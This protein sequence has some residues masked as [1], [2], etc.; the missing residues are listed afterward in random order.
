MTL[1]GL[2]GKVERSL[3]DLV[4]LENSVAGQAQKLVTSAISTA[5]TAS[6]LSPSVIRS[7]AQSGAA[8]A[9]SGAK[10]T[11]SLGNRSRRKTPSISYS[12]SEPLKPYGQKYQIAK[13]ER[14]QKEKFQSA[15]NNSGNKRVHELLH[16][17]AK[18]KI[19]SANGG[20]T[21]SPYGHP[22]E[23]PSEHSSV[24]DDSEKADVP[25]VSADSKPHQQWNANPDPG[26][27]QPG[28]DIRKPPTDSGRDHR[29][30]QS[31][32]NDPYSGQR[33]FRPESQIPS[34]GPPSNANPNGFHDLR[35]N[36]VRPD[37][38]PEAQRSDP[39]DPHSR[40]NRVPWDTS[41]SS[42]SEVP[43]SSH[44]YKSSQQNQPDFL[45][46]DGDSPFWKRALK[47][48]SL[49]PLPNLRK[50]RMPRFRRSSNAYAY[51]NLAAWESTDE[52]KGGRNT[53]IF[54]FFKR[55]SPAPSSFST[56]SNIP[57]RISKH[58]ANDSQPPLVA[59]MLSR[60]NNGNSVSLLR[61]EDEKASKKIG[62]NKAVLDV[63][64]LVSILLGFKL[65]SGFDDLISLPSSWHGLLEICSQNAG[66]AL[67]ELL[68]GSWA[69]FAFLYA[70]LFK[71]IR[72]RYLDHKVDSL[73][74]TVASSVKE[75]SEYAQLYLR[76]LAATP[77]DRH[78]P[79]RLASV[80]KSQVA[81]AVAKSRLNSFVGIVLASLTVMTVS[82]ILPI[83]M[84]FCSTITKIVLLEEWRM[85]PIP[86]EALFGAASAVMQNLFHALESQGAIAFRSFL[87]NPIQF[88]FHLSM[89][90]SLLICALLPVLEERRAMAANVNDPGDDSVRTWN[91]DSAEEWSR[92]GTSSASR[93]SMLSENKSVEN[94]L[95]RWRASHITPL[96]DS[97]SNG[98]SLSTILRF[99]GYTLLATLLAGSPLV[100]FHFLAG[101]TA[102]LSNSLSIFRWDSMLD[103]SFLQ[104]FLLGL[105]YQ[106][107]QNVVQS[108]KYVSVVKKFQTD[109]VSTKEEMEESNKSN[110]DFQ[111]MGSVSPSAGIAVR[112][113]WAAHVTKRAWAIQGA[114]FQCK[115]GEILA[116][117]GEDGNG[118]TR[119][120]TTL[121]EALIF[122]LK[123]T[124]TT[125]K[126]RGVI[127]IGGLDASKWNRKMLKRR[128]GILL[129]DVRM[130]ADSGSL[131]SGWTMEEILEPIDGL[132][133]ANNES[134]QRT[135][136]KAEK[137]A[138]QLALKITGLY[139]TLLARLPSKTST[140][141]TANEED[142]RPTSLKP[143]ST[144]LSPGEWSKLILARVLAQTI[145]NNDNSL[146]SND[147]IENSLLGSILLLD[148]PTTLF[149]E[150]DEG[151][152]YR[153]LRLTGAATVI[154]TNQWASGRFADQICV[155]KNGG[156]VEMGSHNEL[157]AR[158]PQQSLYAAKWHAMTLQ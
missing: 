134:L 7:L 64:F 156:I 139:K 25:E 12:T 14:Q 151:Q 74:S 48:L 133:S 130:V 24:N 82:A 42:N 154:S 146:A 110:A 99:I 126:V 16:T 31:P 2:W 83:A 45:Y 5:S 98:P 135:Y 61:D 27:S 21:S 32:S 57:T 13:E 23:P 150:V 97:L 75:E 103:L 15:R 54:R 145:F 62:R 87:D 128:L 19:I 90:T 70:A 35:T 125:N 3:D 52:D 29:G 65:L 123:R 60:C 67:N 113:L 56:S 49:P 149:S 118:K 17:G 20:A 22:Q 153:D 76:L 127:S 119:L 88:S 124:T 41:S 102:S 158:G 30:P 40:S 132:R 141:F 59:S 157:I 37:P 79:D 78:L 26:N 120:L 46:E 93:L 53:G 144:V 136:T 86:W 122:P 63:L 106:T 34:I 1:K 95:A 131:F 77:M 51:A 18:S 96:G 58:D 91:F 116:V 73:A 8:A 92:L 33:P 39:Q 129:S 10:A 89:F 43:R 71:Y 44:H 104:L 138:M 4:G 140:I 68:E 107:F 36:T 50:L 112:D 9:T 155:V 69:L 142:L 85:W 38:R 80:A 105:V 137:S 111:V 94:A 143:R 28:W 66:S 109:L 101:E 114:N 148:E 152:L 84:A 55:S 108:I 47:G 121:A 6:K 147:K 115:N 11:S 81:N 72:E 100:V 117:L